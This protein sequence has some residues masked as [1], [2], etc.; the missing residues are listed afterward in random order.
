MYNVVPRLIRSLCPEGS[1]SGTLHGNVLFVDIRGF[2]ELTEKLKSEGKTGAD[3]ISSAINAVY[4][5]GLREVFNLGG[6]VVSFI[7]DSFIAV[8]SETP[9]GKLVELCDYMQNSLPSKFESAS[10]MYAGVRSGAAEGLI[11]WGVVNAEGSGTWYVRGDAVKN[12]CRTAYG[13]PV[14][15]DRSFFPPSTI[16]SVSAIPAGL[17]EIRLGP[18]FGRRFVPGN[19]ISLKFGGEFRTVAPVF[20]N[21]DGD[22]SREEL[23]DLIETVLRL[24]VFSGGYFSGVFFDEKGGSILVTFGVPRS[25][26]RAITRALSF[27]A[28]VHKRLSDSVSIGI[29]YGRVYAGF[30]GSRR[31]NSYTVL[32]YAVNTAARLAFIGKKGS[33]LA[34]GNL[35]ERISDMGFNSVNSGPLTLKGHNRPIDCLDIQPGKPTGLRSSGEMV[36]RSSEL[37]VLKKLVSDSFRNSAAGPSVILGPPGI[38]KTKLAAKL[39]ESCFKSCRILSTEAFEMD[40]SSLAPLA[41][42]LS[43][44]LDLP[45]HIVSTDVLERSW[46]SFL[47]KTAGYSDTTDSV[48]ENLTKSVINWLIGDGTPP[49]GGTE[50]DRILRE[51]RILIE[52]WSCGDRILLLTED[53][54]WVDEYA[55]DIFAGLSSIPNLAVVITSRIPLSDRPGFDPHSTVTLDPL[56]EDEVEKLIRNHIEEVPGKEFTDLIMERSGGNPFIAGQFCDLLSDR[57]LLSLSSSSVIKPGEEETIPDEIAE[58]LT[59]RIDR[60]DNRLRSGVLSVSV[61]GN[62]FSLPVF[63]RIVGTHYET[64][65]RD[66]IE[67]EIWEPSE[68]N[69]FRFSH[70][71]LR[72]A[73]CSMLLG[74][75]LRR[76][77]FNAF[78]VL[79]EV[80][81]EDSSTAARKAYHLENAGKTARASEY[82]KTAG[83]YTGLK[84]L[85][86]E[87]AEHFRSMERCLPNSD[88]DRCLEARGKQCSRLEL[89]GEWEEA[90]SIYRDSISLAENNGKK[91]NLGRMLLSFGKLLC[92]KGSLQQ[93]M[94]ALEKAL[95]IFRELDDE[96]MISRVYANMSLYYFHSGEYENAENFAKQFLDIAISVRDKSHECMAY[97]MLAVFAQKRGDMDR[98]LKVNRLQLEL[99]REIGLIECESD[100]LTN[101]GSIYIETGRTDEA[102][103][104]YLENMK[105]VEKSGLYLERMVAISVLGSVDFIRGDLKEAEK[106]YEKVLALARR[107]GD[108]YNESDFILELAKIYYRQERKKEA[109]CLVQKAVQL[110][111][112]GGFGDMLKKHSEVIAR[113]G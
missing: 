30:V 32:G 34:T 16:T 8:F 111:E 61:L 86:R 100:A 83:N 43:R 88:I 76:L 18:A 51:L 64:V 66:G 96:D 110:I 54:Q 11:D 63:Q 73:V 25:R 53:A 99:A 2:S 84:Y 85:N 55:L 28:S 102:Y 31:R 68:E 58:V 45:K 103:T 42:L 80:Y 10:G 6:S 74:K 38:G 36:G 15:K 69:E 82:Y 1:G 35:R 33:I 57:G 92:M 108:S 105:V 75:K 59:A 91:L 40:Y 5:P 19:I 37:S 27:A 13:L 9:S 87:A 112:E 60:L 90:L 48:G 62:H 29:S 93:G 4:R 72:E 104:C 77:H 101:I 89:I 97:G 17:P 106:K 70:V 41:L 94:E 109:E 71:L 95:S 22:I 21:F 14:D 23:H 7:G 98:A 56:S 20:L 113:S 65:L 50:K 44:I 46:K 78:K 12:A 107:I 49:E 52:R 47:G 24:A 79:E 3:R 67:G 39:A 81:P 26:E